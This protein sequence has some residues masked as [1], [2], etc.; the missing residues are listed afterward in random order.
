[1][2]RMTGLQQPVSPPFGLA[3]LPVYLREEKR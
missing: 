2:N 1:M 3:P